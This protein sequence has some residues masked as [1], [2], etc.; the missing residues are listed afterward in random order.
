MES[1]QAKRHDETPVTKNQLGYHST[2]GF[3]Q[4]QNSGN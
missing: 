4:F 2:I 3:I 1:N